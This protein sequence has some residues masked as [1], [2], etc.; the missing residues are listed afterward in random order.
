[1]SKSVKKFDAVATVGSYTDR[2]GQDKK[3]Y[4][5]VGAVFENENGLSLKIEALPLSKDWNGW[6]AFYPPKESRTDTAASSAPAKPV[7]D[8]VDDDIKF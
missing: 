2:N 5:N 1:M 4:L 8:F 7:D 6:I 3:R